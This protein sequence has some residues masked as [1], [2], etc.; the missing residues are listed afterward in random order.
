VLENLLKSNLFS[1]IT[2][3]SG[4]LNISSF[5]IDIFKS[6]N[7][8]INLITSSP[9]A[10]AFYKAG[11]FKKHIPNLYRYFEFNLLKNL[12]NSNLEIYE[13][14]RKNWTF[15][16]KGIW[17]KEKDKHFPTL[18]TIGSSNYSKINMVFNF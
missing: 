10:N 18:V 12:K 4:Y 14:H 8:K 13:F 5:I 17:F 15:H 6:Q 7:Y 3:A 1:E 9:Q 2:L 16:S 11:F